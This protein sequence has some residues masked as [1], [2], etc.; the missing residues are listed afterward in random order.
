VY[1]TN[2]FVLLLQATSPSG[3]SGKQP[4][5]LLHC[6]SQLNSDVW[7]QVVLPKL[8]EHGSAAAVAL[9]CSQL[10]DLCYSSRQSLNLGRLLDR[11]D[12]WCLRSLV[13]ILSLHFPNCLEVSLELPSALS[14]QNMP[15]L[16]PALARWVC[17]EP[18]TTRAA[19]T[20]IALVSTWLG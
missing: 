17:P 2:P 20:L 1:C 7:E 18:I 9:S 6:L 5:A 12:P 8:I 14:Y 16:L 3:S 15:Y 10:R 11:T 4:S 13:Q 19:I